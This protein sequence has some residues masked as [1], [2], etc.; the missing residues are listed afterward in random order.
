MRVSTVD[1]TMPPIIGTAMRRI[2]SDPAPTL[3]RIGKRPAMMATTVIIF[4]RTRSTAPAIIA[5]RTSACASRGLPAG[6]GC[7][8]T[9]RVIEIDEHHHAGLGR[10]AGKR[11][12]ADSN[13]N[14]HIVAEP[15][16]EPGAAD[17]REGDRQHDDERLGQ[18][19]EIEIKQHKNK[20]QRRRDDDAKLGGG[21][22]KY[23]NCPL[24]SM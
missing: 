19:P 13:G 21:A 9:Q 6:I 12:K 2:T 1:E 15:P 3:Q 23:S 4:G 17:E 8:L 14:A 16:H 11:D 20:D 10:D 5:R 18:P 7:S 22:L 24:H